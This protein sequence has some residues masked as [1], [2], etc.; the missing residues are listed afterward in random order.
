MKKIKIAFLEYSYIFS[1]AENSLSSLITYLDKDKFDIRIYFQ[2]PM[3]HHQRYDE[4]KCQKTYL[5]NK[6][7]WWM[8]SD[9]WN[10]PIRGTDFLKRFLFALKL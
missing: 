2:F 7:K 8:G 10:N 3:E 9:Y 1:G 6:K 5:F 4:L